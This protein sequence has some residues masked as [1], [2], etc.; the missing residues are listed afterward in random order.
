VY[1]N[2]ATIRWLLASILSNEPVTRLICVGD[3]M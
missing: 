2:H 1:I 3:V